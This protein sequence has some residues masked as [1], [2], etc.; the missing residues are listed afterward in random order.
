MPGRGTKGTGL[1]FNR[2]VVFVVQFYICFVHLG[3]ATVVN[4]N[5]NL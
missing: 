5:S 4:C 1:D 2:D 3:I